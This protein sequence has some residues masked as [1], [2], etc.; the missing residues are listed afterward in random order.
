[1]FLHA[2][3]R[4]AHVLCLNHHGDTARI[5]HVVHGVDD[6]RRHGFLR[7]QAAAID[8]HQT[9]KFGEAHDAIGWVIGDM[10]LARERHH[11]VFAMRVKRNVA[12]E[13]HV[14]VAVNIAENLVEYIFRLLAVTFEEFLIGF[15]D[16][17]GGFK[18]ALTCRVIACPEQQCSNS[19]HCLFA[20][21]FFD[22]F[23][24]GF[25]SM[26]CRGLNQIIHQVP[27]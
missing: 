12:H 18:Q 1:M 27:P 22:R 17:L 26:K 14:I 15:D 4:H 20:A 19:I 11:V 21:W 16:P 2:A 8:I 7:L 23:S 25:D 10:C 24:A 3:H 5:E 13:D 9:R 6:L